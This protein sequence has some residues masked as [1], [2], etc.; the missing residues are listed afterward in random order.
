MTEVM[1]THQASQEKPA[2]PR[3]FREMDHAVVRFAG[4]SGDGIQLTG[5]L[6]TH[7]SAVL[8]HDVST[9]PEY[10]AEIR[11][12][13]GTRAGV[14][15]FQLNFSSAEIHTPGDRPHMLL[16]LNPAALAVHLP[17][18]MPG[19]T[20]VLD[21]D[22][23]DTAGLGKAGFTGT[24]PRDDGTLAGYQVYRVP[25]TTLTL[26]AVRSLG[27][28]KK[29]ASLCK[30]MFM[31][32]L[33]AWIYDRSVPAVEKQIDSLLERKTTRPAT[34][35][36]YREQARANK[37]AFQ[38]GYNYAD[39]VEVFV[40]RYTVGKA[41]LL[42]G[43]YRRVTGNEATALGFL[44]ASVLS[45]RSLLYA[46][47]PIT[48][49]SD[50]LHELS[51]YRHFGVRTVQAEDEI[52]AIAMAIGAAYGGCLGLTGTSG[53][54]VALKTEAVGLAVMAELPVVIV[55]VQRGG[56][57]TGLPTKT[58]QSDLLQAIYGRNGECPVVVLAA[59]SP[60]HCFEMA[61]EAFRIA[62]RYMTPVFLL[63]DGSIANGTEPWRT[64]KESELP[65]LDL[66]QG[67]PAG[68]YQVY[69]RDP[70][71]LARQWVAPGTPGL[72]HCLGGLEKQDVS[73]KVS[74]DSANH[75]RMVELRI[76]KIQGI[77]RDMPELTV[78]GRAE[79]DLLVLGW[80]G[81]FGAIHHAVER[82]QQ[83]GLSVAAAQLDYL[84]PFPANLGSVLRSYRQVLIPELNAGQLRM[85]IRAQFL[86]DAA[87]LNKITGQ[88]FR[89]SEIELEILRLLGVQNVGRED[90]LSPGKGVHGTMDS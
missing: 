20:I 28:D 17:D 54:G 62:I 89:T 81:T 48:P 66:P 37:L 88:P 46:S 30:N 47:Y 50:I 24:D 80:G 44:A 34:F 25:I 13:A 29:Q 51:K 21:D 90:P 42:P 45:Q 4:D 6:F 58:E 23:F 53:P 57:S 19:G 82:A 73:G 18:L 26:E 65:R 40:C 11:A 9:L 35:D 33:V 70:E 5:S 27:L 55:N 22:T 15:S 10:P 67:V 32:G 68:D 52:A 2:K 85:L 59:H 76:K 74:H 79:G 61:I 31:L 72:E 12:P 77:A 83:L 78:F 41:K 71:T 14:S 1:A 38:A 86:V 84:N 3:Q 87:G 39:T 36:K 49:A 69:A 56:P 16:A 63:S 75:Q 64:P 60:A 8:G 7:D 43:T